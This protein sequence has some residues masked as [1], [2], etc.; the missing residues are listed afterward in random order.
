MELKSFLMLHWGS[1]ETDLQL[2]III[3]VFLLTFNVITFIIELYVIYVQ[4][5]LE[6]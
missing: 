2:N 5:L 6:I 4:T 3:K 1:W